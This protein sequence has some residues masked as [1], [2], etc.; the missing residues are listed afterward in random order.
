M[1]IDLKDNSNSDKKTRV[2]ATV[3]YVGQAINKYNDEGL[4]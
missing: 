4:F 3:K 2:V 1:L